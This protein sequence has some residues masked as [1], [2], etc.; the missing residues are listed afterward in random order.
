[1]MRKKC[2]NSLKQHLD[3]VNAERYEKT[4]KRTAKVIRM[5]S[6]YKHYDEYDENIIIEKLADIQRDLA[7]AINILEVAEEEMMWHCEWFEYDTGVCFQLNEACDL[8]GT[9]LAHLIENDYDQIVFA[10]N[11]MDAS[12]KLAKALATLT[13]WNND[14]EVEC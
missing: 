2:D 7:N 8:L 6:R 13:N 11:L 12:V 3:K 10:S 5:I 9:S 1:M 14:Y 4:L